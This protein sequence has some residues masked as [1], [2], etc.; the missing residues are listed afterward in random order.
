MENSFKRCLMTHTTKTANMYKVILLLMHIAYNTPTV[1]G[2]RFPCRRIVVRADGRR[3]WVLFLA[4]ISWRRP[5]ITGISLGGHVTSLLVAHDDFPDRQPRR[6]PKQPSALMIARTPELGR[7]RN[8][9]N[10]RIRSRDGNS[11]LRH[12][13]PSIIMRNTYK[14]MDKIHRKQQKSRIDD[15]ETSH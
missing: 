8:V 2:S 10:D 15:G 12:G 3:W 1:I 13:W 7:R 14:N 5:V 11:G 6:G 9:N 4:A